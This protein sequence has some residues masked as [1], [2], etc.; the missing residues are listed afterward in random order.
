MYKLTEEGLRKLEKRRDDLEDKIKGLLRKKNEVYRNSGD[1][2]HDNPSLYNLENEI[3]S[4]RRMLAKV[5][6]KIN[7]AE[8]IEEDR[9]NEKEVRIGN[10]VEVEFESGEKETLIVSD[11]ENIDL[12]KGV[13]SYKSP[14]GKAILGAGEGDCCNYVVGKKEITVTVRKIKKREE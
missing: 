5:E 2:W 12:N 3:D 14:L 8:I 7:N 10:R 11:P 9:D 4:L 6:R 13:I 1:E